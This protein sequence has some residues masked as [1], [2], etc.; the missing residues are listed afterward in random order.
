MK[1]EERMKTLNKRLVDDPRA[2]IDAIDTDLLWLLNNRAEVALRVGAMKSVYKM[3]LCDP[4]REDEILDRVA[5][6]NHGPFEEQAVVKI[7]RLIIDESRRLQEKAYPS[8]SPG[9]AGEMTAGDGK[10]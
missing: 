6:E 4:G 10:R 8:G 5:A 9:A 2:E 1:F 7:F 3:P